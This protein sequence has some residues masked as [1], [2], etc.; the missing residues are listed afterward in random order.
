MITYFGNLE[1]IQCASCGISFG[2]TADFIQRRQED[3]SDFKC[4][5]GHLNI[6]LAKTEE[7]K[8][9]DLLKLEKESKE[10]AY[11]RE[12]EA[13]KRLSVTKGALTRT[14]NRIKNGVCPCCN[15]TFQNL[16][17]HMKTKHAGQI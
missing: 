5:M 8:L 16:A 17:L 10:R 12:A 1:V 6:Y 14:K 7:E 15:R 11:A 4:P 13:L 3:H 9:R 2:L